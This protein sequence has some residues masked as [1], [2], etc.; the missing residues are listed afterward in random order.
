MIQTAGEV[1]LECVQCHA[2]LRAPA[3]LAPAQSPPQPVV[4]Q[5]NQPTEPFE[6]YEEKIA[7]L[8]ERRE[9]RQETR[10]Y[11]REDRLSNPMGL[12]G[13][14]I[15]ATTFLLLLSSWMFAKSLPAYLYIAASLAIPAALAGLV[16]SVVGA[17]LMGRPKVIAICGIAV[18]APLLLFMVPIS[19]M[20]REWLQN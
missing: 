14:A 7:D 16:L 15:N 5:F 3:E 18:G 6:F 11:R 1:P 13:F 20:L 19:F 10:Q 2:R 4:I 9:D 17:L 12:A 8:K